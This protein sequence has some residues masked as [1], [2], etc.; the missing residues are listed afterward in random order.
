M[1]M[2]TGVRLQASTVR[3]QLPTVMSAPTGAGGR[4]GS[5]TAK[6]TRTLR[7][8]R[9]PRPHAS[10]RDTRRAMDSTGDQGAWRTCCSSRIGPR[11]VTADCVCRSTCSKVA[12]E[13]RRWP[14]R[15]GV[16]T[17]SG[18]GTTMVDSSRIAKTV[19]LAG[20]DAGA[21]NSRMPCTT[22]GLGRPVGAGPRR[23]GAFG[24][25]L[26]DG[27]SGWTESGATPAGEATGNASTE[28]FCGSSCAEEAGTTATRV[29]E[30]SA[31]ACTATPCPGLC[32]C[33][34]FCSGLWLWLWPAD[35]DADASPAPT[36]RCQ[37]CPAQT[38]KADVARSPAHTPAQRAR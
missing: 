9:H 35:A 10:P 26:R 8:C 4:A 22:A 7:G 31:R 28:A 21:V 23:A 36:P 16:G 18:L 32:P 14:T 6:A 1:S 30:R 11:S 17:P 29:S 13:G 3:A 19:S 34:R 33:P 15:T 20:S 24:T 37:A 2:S 5:V 38:S 27:G 12:P 25:T